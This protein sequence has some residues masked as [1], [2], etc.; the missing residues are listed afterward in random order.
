MGN[1]ANLQRGERYVVGTGGIIKGRFVK[2]GSGGDAGKVIAVT[3]AADADL[4]IGVAQETLEEGDSAF[5]PTFGPTDIESADAAIG[6]LDALT[7]NASGQV[8]KQLA[9]GAQVTE[10]VGFSLEVGTAIVS[11]RATYIKIEL[12]LLPRIPLDGA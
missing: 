2:L 9:S 7:I 10:T 12:A 5:I 6:K 11:S 3:A 1:Y 4:V 8:T